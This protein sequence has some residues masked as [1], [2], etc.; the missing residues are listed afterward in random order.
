MHLHIDRLP[1]FKQNIRIG[2]EGHLGDFEDLCQTGWRVFQTLII[3][4]DPPTK[5]SLGFTEALDKEN[6]Q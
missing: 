4:W 3:Y 6:I 5:P 2:K 1:K